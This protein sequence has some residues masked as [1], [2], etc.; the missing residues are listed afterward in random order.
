MFHKHVPSLNVLSAVVALFSAVAKCFLQIF[1]DDFSS[2]FLSVHI[3]A[4]C[5]LAYFDIENTMLQ[6][7]KM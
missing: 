4:C 7:N 5:V 1:D 3:F 6:L 2:S